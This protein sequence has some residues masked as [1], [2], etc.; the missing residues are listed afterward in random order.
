MSVDLK[1]TAAWQ[2]VE[3]AMREWEQSKERCLEEWKEHEK[4]VLTPDE[5][6]ENFIALGDYF[7]VLAMRHYV[8]AAK[9][10]NERQAEF[11]LNLSTAWQEEAS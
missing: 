1:Q 3:R 9:L 4:C 2:S 10:R 5:F 11:V 6:S 8:T 7:T